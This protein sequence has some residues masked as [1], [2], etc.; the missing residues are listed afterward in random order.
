MVSTMA[1][2][3]SRSA[4]G[5]RADGVPAGLAGELGHAHADQRE[6]EADEGADVLEQHD[7]QLGDLGVADEGD[8]PLV[9]LDGPRLVD[10]GP[11]RERLEDDRDSPRM[12]TATI[13]LSISWGWRSFST[14][15]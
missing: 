5:E 10:G 2:T 13:G 3:V 1:I 12:P 4:D 9:A 11:Q 6:H 15:S 14:P 7:G 8:P